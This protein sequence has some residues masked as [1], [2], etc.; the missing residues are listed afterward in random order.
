MS[1]TKINYIKLLF[2]VFL[3]FL[4]AATEIIAVSILLGKTVSVSFL[5]LIILLSGLIYLFDF[6]EEFKLANKGKRSFIFIL[7]LFLVLFL[8]ILL[9]FGNI[10]SVILALILLALGFL[11]NSFFKKIT[12]NIIGFKDIFVS[13][14]WNMIVL[15]FFL[16]HDYKIGLPEILLLVFIFMRDFINISYCDIK[17]IATDSIRGLKTFAV[18]IGKSKLLILLNTINIV[19]AIFIFTLVSLGT[20]PIIGYA[21]IIPAVYTIFAINNKKN[22]S[23]NKVDAEYFVWLLSVILFAYLK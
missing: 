14:M 8:A 4:G 18:V 10:K 2:R 6:L 20:L 3:T 9:Y 5:A 1:N 21:L 22:Y 19:S 17:D 13:L 7:S 11:Y 15:L 23:P 12:S 16:Y